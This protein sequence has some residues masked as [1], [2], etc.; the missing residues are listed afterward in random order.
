MKKLVLIFS[1][2]LCS[3]V[4]AKE[5]VDKIVAIVDDS[6]ITK[7]D[8]NLALEAAK[9]SGQ[10]Q[11]Y[12]KIVQM[13]VN[14]KVLEAEIEKAKITITTQEV[15]AAMQKMA[16]QRGGTLKAF[17]EELVKNGYVVSVYREKLEK[18]L[19]RREFLKKMVYPMV[20]ISDTDL[21]NYYKKNLSKF[22]TF[23]KI[24]FL[25]IFLTPDSIPQGEDFVGFVKKTAAELKKKGKFS[26]I[27]KKYSKGPFAANGGDSGLVD[28]S[29]LPPDLL[30]ILF[31]LK[32]NVVSDPFPLGNKGVFIFKVLKKDGERQK[33]FNEVREQV[34]NMYAEEKADEVL[35]DYL[36][37]AR[38]RHYVEIR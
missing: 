16:A 11:T 17:E 35:E 3:S 14:Q 25:E 10:P 37:E 24:Q 12:S 23:Q 5:V 7:S 26:D 29:Q 1:F 15:D 30:Q 33:T 6:V 22:T 34:R 13:L 27:A 18:D 28:I 20:R 38:S 32:M 9:K 4:L 31:T 36:M 2:F 8:V 21:E 19:K